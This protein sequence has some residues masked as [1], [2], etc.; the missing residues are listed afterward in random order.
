MNV[1]RLAFLWILYGMLFAQKTSAQNNDCIYQPNIRSVKLHA[2]ADQL[3]YPILKLNSTDRIELHFDDLDA[4]VKY[5]SYT[6]VLCNADWTTAPISQFDYMRGFANVRINTYR[7]ASI[8]LTRY[9]HY[10][11]ILPDK[12]TFP[13][14]SGNYLLKVFTNGDTSKTVFTKRFLVV[15]MKAGIAATVLQPF[16]TAFAKTHQK[17]QFS[18]NVQSIKPTNVFQQIKVVILQNFRWDQSIKNIQPTFIR[19][20]IL[21]YNT[22]NESLFPAQ[23]EW[24]WLNLTSLRLQTDRIEKG[25]YTNKGQTLYVKPDGDRNGLRYM[26]YRDANG[27]CQYSTIEPV[28]P[29]WQGDYA[30]VWFRYLPSNKQPIKEQDVYL[31][32][33]LTNY[34]LTEAH[35]LN[36]NP[37]TGFYENKQMLKQGLYDYIYLL[38]NK[39]TGTI[40]SDLTEGNWFETE[41]NYT[42][43]VY[44]RPLG[45]RAD[46]LIAI[47]L[48]NSI[49]NRPS[50]ENRLL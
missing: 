41:N 12:N 34:E 15:D 38:K 22:E 32:G 43:L 47:S 10:S 27:F 18:I 45:G 50:M 40:A 14:R 42:I 35:K 28:N 3:S 29:Y 6:F 37:E 23:K 48:I 26:Y 44:Y 13:T 25:D 2:Y 7:N 19:Q 4:D 21:E 11:A 17:I 39:K 46:E 30:T 8:A 36:Y 24:R 33:E 20:N 16:N 5:Y 31:Y 1:Q 49:A 9:T